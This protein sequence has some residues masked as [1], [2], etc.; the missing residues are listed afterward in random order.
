MSTLREAASEEHQALVKALIDKFVTDGLTVVKA[1]YEGYEEPYAIGR[2][3][4]D[5]IATNAYELYSIGEAKRCDDLTSQRS[6]EQFED[7]SNS[8]M[9]SGRSNGVTVPF[10]I[11]TP[12]SCEQA[13]SLVL[14]QL[15][16]TAKPNVRWWVRG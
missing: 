12:K 9:T 6:R 5:I 8:H 11:I 15:G 2:H 16:L 1:A 4:P 7:F 13:T 3:E 10:H 14:S